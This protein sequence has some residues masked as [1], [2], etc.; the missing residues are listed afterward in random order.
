[1]IM[2]QKLYSEIK[3]NS[4]PLDFRDIPVSEY[5]VFYDQVAE[6]LKVETNHCLAYYALI[7]K[8]SWNYTVVLLMT[9]PGV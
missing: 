5:D 9:L 7:L 3:N 2:S 8:K 6:L 1:M 4:T